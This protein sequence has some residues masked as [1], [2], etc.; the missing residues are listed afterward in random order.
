MIRARSSS[1]TPGL[2]RNA[3]EMAALDTFR[4]RAN[5]SKLTEF[6]GMGG[7]RETGVKIRG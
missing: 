5:S 4:R 7:S 3:S 2:P 1:D 6:D